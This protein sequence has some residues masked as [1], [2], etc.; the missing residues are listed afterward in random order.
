MGLIWDFELYV[1]A[2]T[3][4]SRNDAHQNY[5]GEGLAKWQFNGTGDLDPNQNFTWDSQ[6]V[7]VTAPAGWTDLNTGVEPLTT[8]PRF[9]D[10]VNTA[11]WT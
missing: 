1:V 5:V 7:S 3:K 2:L 6:T 11:G 9:N 10:V 8:G 4:D